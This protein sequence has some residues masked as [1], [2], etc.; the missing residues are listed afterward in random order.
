MQN[1]CAKRVLACARNMRGTCAGY[2]WVHVLCV[3]DFIYI[4]F[5]WKSL[6]E[7]TF[8]SMYN[9]IIEEGKSMYM[10]VNVGSEHVYVFTIIL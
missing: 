8:R 6:C 10:S 1:M 5:S 9:S 2:A 3:F 4:L 7:R